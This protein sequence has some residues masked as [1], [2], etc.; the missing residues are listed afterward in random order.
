MQKCW[1]L[2]V[3]I[4][5]QHVVFEDEGQV[6]TTFFGSCLAEELLNGRGPPRGVER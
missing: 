2:G 6:D 1:R 5:M 4:G 3:A